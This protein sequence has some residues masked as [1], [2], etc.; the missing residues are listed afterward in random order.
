[1]F[2]RYNTV[3]LI[4]ILL[5]LPNLAAVAQERTGYRVELIILRHLDADAEPRALAELIAPSGTLDLQKTSSSEPGQPDDPFYLGPPISDLLPPLGPFPDQDPPWSEIVLLENRSEQMNTVWRNLRLSGAFRPEAFLAWEQP[6]D[7]PF[8]LLRVHGDGVFQV[9]DPWEDLRLADPL[10]PPAGEEVQARPWLDYLFQYFPEHG[11]V[12][13]APLP[14]PK[15]HYV[16]EGGVALRRTRFL[17]FDI[18]IDFRMPAP[19]AELGIPG[20]PLLPEYQGHLVHELKQSRQ[21]RTER[22]EYF[23]SPVLGALL[24]ITEFQTE[25]EEAIK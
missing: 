24:W 25:E 17:H 16:V 10:A 1:M 13:L 19:A 11:E 5:F 9:D 12:R 20:P 23:D 3:F 6:A 2:S 22:M 7:P 4:L 15:F 21:V 18:D 8:P 14:E